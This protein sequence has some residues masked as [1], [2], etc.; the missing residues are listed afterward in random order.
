MVHNEQPISKGKFNLF[1]YLV[2]STM[3]FLFGLFIFLNLFIFR[4]SVHPPRLSVRLQDDFGPVTLF[5][6]FQT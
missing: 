3:V 6:N 2:K 4:S 5:K 1:G